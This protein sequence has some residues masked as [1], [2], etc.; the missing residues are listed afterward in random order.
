M[1]RKTRISKQY[2][3][4]G[5]GLISLIAY[6]LIICAASLIRGYSI[7]FW[8]FPLAC[9]LMLVTHFFAS[10]YLLG[11]KMRRFFF[12]TSGILL[13]ISIASILLASV[14]YDVSF[15]GQW[16][17]Q[18]T[19]DKLK[20][21]FNPYLKLLPVP[22]SEPIP[23]SRD[24]WCTG[25]DKSVN[26]STDSPI[27]FVNFKYLN[28]NHLSKGT[29]ITEA[30]IYKLT[31]RI[32]SGKAV[33]LIMLA[34]TFFLCLSLLYKI[35]RVSPAKKWLISIL[36]CFNPVTVTQLFTYCVDG[37]MVSI[38]LCLAITF[39]LFVLEEN[40]YY[41]LALGL[42]ITAGVNIKYTSLVYTGIFCIGFLLILMIRKDWKRFRRVFYMCSIASIFGACFV[43]FHPYLT[44]LITTNQVFDG[45]QETKNE[46][47]DI[48]PPLFRNMNRF[49]KFFVSL[50]T[51]S[52]DQAADKES[53]GAALK[54]PFS[55][56]KKDLLN[57]NNA[58]LK[59]S[60]F[61][62]FF[63]G[64]LLICVSLLVWMA[65][66]FSKQAVFRY[67]VLGLA[68]I[69]VSVFIVPEPWWARFVPQLWFFPVIVLLISECLA[70]LG[71]RILGTALYAS[72]GI[73]LVW[74][75]MGIFYNLLIS[76]HIQY[77]LKQ[78]KTLSE[79][80]SVEYC[81]YRSF[82]S[83]RLRFI[84]NDISFVEKKPEG[85][86]IY[87]VIHSNTRFGT[88]DALPDLPKP[89]LMKLNEKFKGDDSP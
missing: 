84:E 43:G 62:P 46:I 58:E 55:V 54:I 36:A 77:Q 3:L 71:R 32:E 57:A 47:Y 72:L 38:L 74:S 75:L 13:A 83:N 65:F 30:A 53:V 80:I 88:Q 26:D 50:A 9:V 69:L 70:P 59:L 89:F 51:H 2:F 33:N 61:G 81:A 20:T 41:L 28:L 56:N 5:L 17:H 67:G 37:V 44:N 16:Y 12:R 6:T 76:S 40:K 31:N 8:Q 21:G 29:E 19:I 49:E 22:I 52:D 14:I 48:T 82:T 23:H 86:N 63:S 42:L 18:E 4:V 1:E 79:P 78:I 15:D 34:G 66:R 35:E 27:S 10:E 73:N 45:L 87:N 25:P 68:I 39:C 11:K 24:A 7:S 85:P 64:I 60:A